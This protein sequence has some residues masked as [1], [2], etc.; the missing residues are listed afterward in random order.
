MIFPLIGLYKLA[1]DKTNNPENSKNRIS[2]LQMMLGEFG[3]D[4]S[5]F[6]YSRDILYYTGTAQPSFLLVTPREF[7]LFVQGGMEFALNESWIERERVSHY[8]GYDKIDYYLKKWNVKG[9]VLGL[10][11]DIIPAE[12]Y[13]DIKR[14]F[15]NF[16][17]RDISNLILQQRMEK[18]PL[19]IEYIRKAC[20]ILHKGHEKLMNVFHEGMTELDLSAQI[21]EAHRLHG[22]EGQYFMRQFD[23][24]MGRG[25]LASGENLSRITGRVLSISGV[26]LSP[27]IPAGASIKPINKGDLFVVDIP[28]NYNGYHADQSRTYSVGRASSWSR[29]MHEGLKEIEEMI[30]RKIKPGMSF[31]EIYRDA[32][33]SADE[34]GIGPYFMRIG[35][36]MRRVDFIGHGI[37]L[38]LN[39]PPIIGPKGKNSVKKGMVI[40]IEIECTRSEKEVVKLE[41][42]I[43]ITS[44][45]AEILTIT[46][47]I[48]FEL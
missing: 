12:L 25:P 20:S 6:V 36:K 27:S 19:E 18:D 8:E 30:L 24:F 41:D 7:A 43:H 21:E 3:I 9:G 10:E 34:L 17:I 44:G 47:R 39:E 14:R 28:A 11:M 22:H 5:I 40:T 4:A 1:E 33:N 32:L 38:E 45:G 16:Q 23:F 26:G 15:P 46:P 31:N 48:L 35:M 42:M 37:G 29:E 2:Q 13:L